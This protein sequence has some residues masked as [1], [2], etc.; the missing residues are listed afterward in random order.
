MSAKW[1]AQTVLGT[2]ATDDVFLVID[3]SA[4]ESKQ[5][6]ASNVL[7]FMQSPWGTNIDG[8]GFD[9]LNVGTNI[10]QIVTIGIPVITQF[11]N[12]D[13]VDD[14]TIGQ[15]DFKG[16]D[17]DSVSA[18]VIYA[19]ILGN[20]LL[21]SS[22]DEYGKITFQ[23]MSGGSLVDGLTLDADAGE[24]IL[25][26]DIG[27][28]IN[29]QGSSITDALEVVFLNGGSGNQ[30]IIADTD[31]TF[32]LTC[33]VLTDSIRFR[34]STT[35][36]YTFTDDDASF[37]NNTISAVQSMGLQDSS[38][39]GTVTFTPSSSQTGNHN[40]Q[41]PNLDDNAEIIFDNQ[42]QTM[43]DKT[44]SLPILAG[45]VTHT[46]PNATQIYKFNADHTIPTASDII[47]EI[48]FFDDDDNSIPANVQYAGITGEI[49][50]SA[51]SN[52]DGE[53]ALKVAINGTLT[54][55][56]RIDGNANDI[57]LP[58]GF[59]TIGDESTGNP[60][61]LKLG[62]DGES[63]GG[64]GGTLVIQDP[65]GGEIIIESQDQTSTSSITLLFPLMEGDNEFVVTE[66]AQTL[67]AKTLDT[68][69]M[70]DAT[71]IILDTTT[72]TKIGTGTLQKIGFWNVTPIVQ[73]AHIAD[74]TDAASAIS[75]L[76]LLLAQIATLG[77]QAS[78]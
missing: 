74:A 22:G 65:L 3:T 10:Q 1:S 21:V 36:E 5:I 51:A 61:F 25:G 20:S 11:L 19:S 34:W 72:G 71:D 73:P 30:H 41:I 15:I 49:G 17:D 8:G 31:T 39:V 62:W 32:D 44:L 26:T 18:E 28:G 67:L 52:I 76:N 47:G 23:V 7:S 24:L 48:Q 57:L 68:L 56:I 59:L 6:T 63:T 2:L 12:L 54:E 27:S 38:G 70:V 16:R 77:L 29:M 45:L 35:S 75:Q 58:E 42:V 69:T 66:Q 43:S 46:Q 64:V 4:T 9:L 60:G 53:M 78:S 37:N 14:T 13:G 33:S 55:F 40:M 50:N